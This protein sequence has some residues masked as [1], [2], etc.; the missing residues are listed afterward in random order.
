MFGGITEEE[1]SR[2][3]KQGES[4]SLLITKAPKSLQHV[5]N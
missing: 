2:L 4:D 5:K 3:V 1:K